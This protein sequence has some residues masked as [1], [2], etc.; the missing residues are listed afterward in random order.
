MRN[1]VTD[2]AIHYLKHKDI[3]TEKIDKIKPTKEGLHVLYKDGSE[4]IVLVEPFIED[5]RARLDDVDTS[6]DVLIVVFNSKE[7]FDAL[8]KDWEALIE[9][10]KVTIIFINPFSMMDTK[11]IISPYFHTRIA[12][13]D[14]LDSG[15]KSLFNSVEEITKKEAEKK[16]K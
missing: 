13:P 9:F 14:S 16:V 5:F 11:W 4:K 1:F 2:W 15:L 6:K 12:D 3:L 10:S 7:N 8:Q